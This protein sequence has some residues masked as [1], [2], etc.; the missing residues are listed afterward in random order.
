MLE[1]KGDIRDIGHPVSTGWCGRTLGS[2]SEAVAT[3]PVSPAFRRGM[4]L[5]VFEGSNS[6]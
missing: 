6:Y 5:L 1:M 4:H 2:R 3:H